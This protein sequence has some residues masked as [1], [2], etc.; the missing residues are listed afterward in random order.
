VT[1][2]ELV[3]VLRAWGVTLQPRGEKLRV[4]PVSR[5]TSD[6]LAQLRAL[7]PAV[8][9]LLA[10]NP[11]PRSLAAPATPPAEPPT[12]RV[13]VLPRPAYAPPWPDSVVGLGPRTVGPFAPCEGCG[14]GS[15]IRYGCAVLCLVCA[16]RASGLRP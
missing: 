2:P 12:A 6:E 1:A 10:A 7:K 13:A 8:L 14:R 16:E 4:R 5:L 3:R 15:W 11:K 9:A